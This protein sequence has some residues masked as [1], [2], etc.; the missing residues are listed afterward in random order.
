MSTIS[1]LYQR[2]I[3]AFDTP[4]LAIPAAFVK[5]YR[6]QDHIP[7]ELE[8]FSNLDEETVMSCQAAKHAANDNPVLLTLDNVGCIA[9]AIGLGLVD[10]HQQ[11]PLPGKR[12]YTCVMHEQVDLDPKW[13]APSPAQ[14]T[15]GTVYACHDSDR[16]EFCLFGPDDVGRFKDV[17]TARKAIGQM[18]A[19]QPPTTKAVFFYSTGF[20][21]LD[22][23][24]DLV[25]MD[26]RPVELTKLVQAL[27]FLTG[28]RVNA[29]MG[30]LRAMNSDLIARPYLT[31]QINVSPYC[32]GSRALTKFG[33]CQMGISF[34]YE[35]FKI[36]VEGLEQS[37]TG[38]PF[39]AY[40]GF[41]E[42]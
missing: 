3:E 36:T 29:S 41:D 26:V 42:F 10:Q 40:P 22:I 2:M 21:A 20:Q 38:Y 15:D 12:I 13:K 33:P 19:I 8:E 17:A 5:I 31:G 27:A 24:P 28:E 32:L 7:A 6:N 25:V 4:G 30:P 11:T 9:A 1:G 37:R 23:E 39:A 35:K 14:F 18:M 16:H 34:P